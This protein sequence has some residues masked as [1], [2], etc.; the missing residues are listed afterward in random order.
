MLGICHLV[1]R[2]FIVVN[3]RSQ[4]VTIHLNVG[5]INVLRILIRRHAS[6]LS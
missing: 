6:I 2:R 4:G 3:N 5:K 1:I